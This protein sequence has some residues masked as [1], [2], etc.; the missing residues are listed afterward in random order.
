MMTF[1]VVWVVLAAAVT[2][3]AMMRRAS[4]NPRPVE[5][6]VN[7]QSGKGLTVVAVIYSLVLL[8]GFLYVGWQ[9][10]VELIK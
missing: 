7:R 6:P 10:G 4:T 5:V 3:I 9:H 8:V 2:V 1:S